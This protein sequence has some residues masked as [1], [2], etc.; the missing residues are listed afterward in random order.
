MHTKCIYLFI[1]LLFTRFCFTQDFVKDST[2]IN[3]GNNTI[4]PVLYSID[5]VIDQ[6]TE[7]SSNVLRISE[8]KQ[9]RYIPV[10]Y[11]FVTQQSIASNIKQ[12]IIDDTLSDESINLV[13]KK[14]EI[15][16]RG[17]ILPA[18]VLSAQI[19]IYKGKINSRKT[20]DGTLIYETSG[21]KPNKRNSQ[22][23]YEN[24]IDSWR[25]DFIIDIK[26][27][28]S[29]HSDSI[30][31]YRIG[32]EDAKTRLYCSSAF[33]YGIDWCMLDVNLGFYEPEAS[34]RFVRH[35]HFFRYRNE[36]RF[37]SVAM[38]SNASHFY[39]RINKDFISEIEGRFCVGFN[40]WRDMDTFKHKLYDIANVNASIKTGILYSPFDKKGISM[41]G[42][43][44]LDSYYIY[45]LNIQLKP[46]VYLIFGI[47]L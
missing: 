18:S 40:R 43:L 34:K 28:Q 24:L 15:N 26:R 17:G 44:L 4:R 36:K 25:S 32:K 47:S 31:H 5:S 2:V 6:R 37:E 38:G 13:L 16:H 42:G 30:Y 12:L 3:F 8:K 39:C 23:C 9:Y 35:S 20:L 22:E 14:F 27:L 29:N 10:D 45:S 19:S 21:K 33:Y 1:L 11:Y 46:A 7:L 41:G